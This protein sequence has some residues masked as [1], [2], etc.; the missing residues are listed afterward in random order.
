VKFNIVTVDLTVKNLNLI[1]VAA[2]ASVQLATVPQMAST[3]PNALVGVRPCMPDCS[4]I[5]RRIAD[6]APALTRSQINGGYFFEINKK[7]FFDDVCF[8]KTRTD[9]LQ[10]P[11]AGPN[12]G[13]GDSLLIVDGVTVANNCDLPGY[14]VPT[15]LVLNGTGSYITKLPKGGERD[16]RRLARVSHPS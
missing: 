1:G 12:C 3:V 2:N 7:D 5:A 15:A 6:R 14:A 9:A 8:G 11:S 13:L 10:P 4:S 16:R